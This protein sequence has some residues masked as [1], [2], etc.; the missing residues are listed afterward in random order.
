MTIPVNPVLAMFLTGTM[1]R[2][3]PNSRYASIETST[4][5]QPD[6]SEVSYLLRRFVPQQ[7]SV[8]TLV[9]HVLVQG[10]RL[11]GITARYL[12]DPEQFYRVCD[13]NGVMHPLE[14]EVPGRVIRITLPE[15]VSG[16]NHG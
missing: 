11:D 13:G 14:L 12:G 7:D 3:P 15:G 5:T 6:G 16:T 2:F 1:R 4:L 9:E 10:E 8:T